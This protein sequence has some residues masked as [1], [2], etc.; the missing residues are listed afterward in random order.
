MLVVG[1]KLLGDAVYGLCEVSLERAVRGGARCSRLQQHR[2]C[3][4]HKDQKAVCRCPAA[5]LNLAADSNQDASP[6]FNAGWM[7]SVCMHVSQLV[8]EH[9][10]NNA[11]EVHLD[12][13]VTRCSRF[14]LAH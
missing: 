10:L 8:A 1:R 2:R 11:S 7:E 3:V 12:K 14:E 6:L 5:I 4:W 13:L 9:E